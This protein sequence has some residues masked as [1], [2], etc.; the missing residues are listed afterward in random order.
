MYIKLIPRLALLFTCL[1]VFVPG[2]HIALSLYKYSNR[3][4]PSVF[5]P[6]A[7]TR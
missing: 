5:R 4:I 3:A 1:L 6:H 7:A 2:G